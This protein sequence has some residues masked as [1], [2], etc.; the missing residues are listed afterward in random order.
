MT[1]KMLLYLFFKIKCYYFLLNK[2]EWKIIK[3]MIKIFVEL[4]GYV[5]GVLFSS[6]EVWHV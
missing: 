4:E 1:I 5:K 6:H 2:K 3:Q